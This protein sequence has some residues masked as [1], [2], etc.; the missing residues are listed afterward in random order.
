MSI[1][2]NISLFGSSRGQ[3]VGIS[4]RG[5]PA[6]IRVDDMF[7][8]QILDRRKVRSLGATSRRESD[9]PQVLSGIYK[10]YTTSETICVIFANEDA[11]GGEDNRN[12][13]PRPG[14]ADYTA[15][16]ASRGFADLRGGG[17]YSGRL[18]LGLCY[19]G[20]LA[21][22]FLLLRDIEV[23]AKLKSIGY[24]MDE[25]MD[26]VNPNLDA[27]LDCQLM[28]FSMIR[29]SSVLQAKE[30][31][32]KAQYRGDSLSSSI[33]CLIYNFPPGLGGNH[34]ES[35]ES[36]LS[37]GLFAVPAVK[38]LQFGERPSAL[39][40]GS[41]YN[42]AFY[43][44]EDDNLLTSSNNCGGILGGRSNGMPIYFVVDM[45]PT[46]SIGM[47]QNTVD[48]QKMRNV[49]IEQ[50]G[51]NDVCI[52]IR[53]CPVIESVAALWAMYSLLGANE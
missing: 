22:Q 46:P 14:H 21:K 19:A 50:H 7:I 32:E 18:T 48:F 23:L 38:S 52:G 9:V 33:E 36:V 45:K 5:I 42:D 27:W 53:A 29:E 16:L 51:R 8:Q 43:L 25:D 35:I 49:E 2:D 11:E 20:A 41:K 37:Q 15:N 47:R 39:V 1:W 17:A 3:C 28:D 4:L 40:F 6:G 31:I 24:V 12:I 30:L 34:F 44:D 10:G 26:I 13:V